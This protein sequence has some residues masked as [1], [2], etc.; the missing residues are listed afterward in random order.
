VTIP[1]KILSSLIAKTAFAISNEESRYTLNGALLLPQAGHESPWSLPTGIV[2]PLPRRTISLAGLTRECAPLV[3]EKKLLRKCSVSRG[4]A[5]REP[6]RVEFALDDSHLFFRVGERLLISRM[7]T[8]QFPNYEAV[9]SARETT[10][11]VV[12]ERR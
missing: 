6:A 11:T 2:W 8:G 5:G 10:S 9:L 3:A 7:L 1:A 12:I 4:E